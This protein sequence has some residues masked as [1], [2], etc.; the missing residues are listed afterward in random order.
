MINY[1]LKHFASFRHAYDGL[2]WAIRT[3]PN[4]R[5]H[6]IVSLFVVLAG[7]FFNV[8]RQ[9]WAILVLTISMGLVIETLNT[10][11]EAVSDAITHEWKEEIKIAKDVSAAAMLTYAVG[12]LCV[13]LLLFVPK[14]L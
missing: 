2:S 4:Y 6:L 13:A 14:M 7:I 10:A 1:I 9:E 12:A 5:V 8:S 11:I 3:Q